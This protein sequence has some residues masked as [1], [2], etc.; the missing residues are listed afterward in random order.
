[1][2]IIKKIL[3]FYIE[4]FKNQSKSSKRLWVIIL[5][6]LFI[7]FAILKVF[8]FKDFLKSKNLNEQEKS[9]YIINNLTK[10][11]NESN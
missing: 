11:N 8:F 1:M 2:T 7:M 3:N 4:G 10:Q 5:I 9:E 6:K